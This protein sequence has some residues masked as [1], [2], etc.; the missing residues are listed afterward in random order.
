MVFKYPL[1]VALFGFDAFVLIPVT[2]M[3]IP[4]I[5]LAGV[6]IILLGQFPVIFFVAREAYRKTRLQPGADKW[7]T[8]PEKWTSTLEAYIKQA[9]ENK[10]EEKQYDNVQSNV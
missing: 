1:L 6:G 4:M 9:K 2:V 7:E 3:T 10:E 8:S 5:G